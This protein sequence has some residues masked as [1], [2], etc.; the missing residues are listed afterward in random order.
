MKYLKENQI[1]SI[2]QHKYSIYYCN[3]EKDKKGIVIFHYNTFLDTSF[4]SDF[5]LL[6]TFG[7]TT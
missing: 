4:P 7:H 5:A 6:L 1:I 3:L 2:M